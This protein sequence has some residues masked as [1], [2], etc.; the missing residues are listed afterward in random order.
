MLTEGCDELVKIIIET[1]EVMVAELKRVHMDR[2]NDI[3]VK[4]H[5]WPP[6]EGAFSPTITKQEKALSETALF[7]H[8][9]SFV[10]FFIFFFT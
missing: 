4:E 2:A 1:L 3:G 7:T 6:R 9:L 8:L 10:I 5:V